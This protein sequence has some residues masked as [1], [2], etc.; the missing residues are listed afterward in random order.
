LADALNPTG[1]N[2]HL[3]YDAPRLPDAARAIADALAGQDPPDRAYF[4]ANAE[5]FIAS[6]QPLLHTIAAIENRHPGAP[7]AYTERVPQYLLDA[8]GLQVAT[9]PGFA[10]AIED[11]TEPSPGDAQ[12]MNDLVAHGDID[13]LLYNAQAVTPVTQRLRALAA[14]SNVPVVPVTETLP[15]GMTFQQ[16][17]T[18]QARALMEAL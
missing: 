7:V 3:W 14:R 9:P 12:R 8:A 2:P 16:W 6:L 1:S 15:P 10:Q 11:G 18:S 4:R 5:R 13:A 17:Q